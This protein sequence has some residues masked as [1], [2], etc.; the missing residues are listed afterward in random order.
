MGIWR[1]CLIGAIA[2]VAASASLVATSAATAAV[3]PARPCSPS[4]RAPT[5]TGCW[6]SGEVVAAVNIAIPWS[7]VAMSELVAQHAPVIQATARQI[8]ARVI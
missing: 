4:C 5:S 7:P 6:T 8:A 1:A 3:P 2:V